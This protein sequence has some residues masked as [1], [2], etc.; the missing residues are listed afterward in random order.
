MII[1]VSARC[2]AGVSA[3]ENPASPSSVTFSRESE[4][5]MR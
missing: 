2:P 3:A 4:P 5:T 1:I